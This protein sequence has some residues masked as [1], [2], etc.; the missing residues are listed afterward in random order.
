MWVASV[1]ERLAWLDE[2]TSEETARALPHYVGITWFNVRPL[3]LSLPSI[4]RALLLMLRWRSS[5]SPAVR[6]GA[7]GTALSS[8]SRSLFSTPLSSRS[9][10]TTP[11]S[12]SLSTSRRAH[13]LPPAVLPLRRRQRRDCIGDQSVDRERGNNGRG[14][15][16]GQR[17]ERGVRAARAAPVSRSFSSPCSFGSRSACLR[18]RLKTVEA[19]LVAERAQTLLRPPRTAL[20][21][22]DLLP[23]T[24]RRRSTCA[25]APSSTSSKRGSSRGPLRP[26]ARGT[27]RGAGGTR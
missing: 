3:V 5:F 13:A 14:R 2:L 19:R 12:P 4:R 8:P 15:G 11:S 16:D 24:P 23:L 10:S 17:V 1:E 27:R 20:L 25:A 22:L 7:S 26:A 18:E 6:Q 9:P 21:K